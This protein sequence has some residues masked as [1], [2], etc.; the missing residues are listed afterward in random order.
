M[1]SARQTRIALLMALVMGATSAS[2]AA[3]RTKKDAAKR[4]AAT[5]KVKTK[6]APPEET[7]EPAAPMEAF[8][9]S[10]NEESAEAPAPAPAPAATA[11]Q[12]PAPAPTP[13]VAPAKP[14]LM[15]AAVPAATA[16][17]PAPEAAP[18]APVAAPAAQ[19]WVGSVAVFAV[20]REPGSAE[21]AL[22]LQEEL[23]QQ[24]GGRPDVQ[25]VNLAEAFPPPAPASLLEGDKL[26]EEGKSLYDN[27][28]PEAAMP[29]FQAAADFYIE[30]PAELQ[31]E[32]L[33]RIY[34]FMG[35]SQL[36]NG[37][38]DAANVAFLRALAAEPSV[39]PD[40]GLFG[41][42][43]QSAFAAAQEE[44]QKRGK[45]TLTIETTPAGAQVTVRGRKLGVTPVTG[46]ELPAG[47]HAVV[48]SYPGYTPYAVYQE[49]ASGR[50]TEMK[51]T[52]EPTPGLA[53]MLDAARQASTEKAFDAREMPA[54]AGAI[55]D[56]L[57][58]RY[59][60]LAAVQ[61]DRK[62]RPRAELQAWDT[63]TKSR[64]RGISII[65]GSTDKDETVAGAS[66]RVHQFVTGAN[67]PGDSSFAMPEFMKKPW[68]WAAVG[69]AALV[70]TGVVVYANSGGVPGYG[71]VSGTAGLGF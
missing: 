59:V 14:N 44:S 25:L 68:F 13:A 7:V 42:E 53:P 8:G 20:A 31:P 30:H 41:G 28:D 3:K 15:P 37:D 18:T 36:L 39:Q 45:G 24:L 34:I 60:V 27:L 47:R 35:A 17:K 52:L 70:T 4:P 57:G 58:A 51:Q 49:V 22:R 16:Q 43:V 69:G 1:N 54:E 67:L 46:V 56:R 40:N 2:A 55:A 6:K 11:Q 5:K 66:E 61:R 21:A 33:A 9:T 71:P 10:S 29:K 23:S 64:L 26:F 19:D 50:P 12:A 32:R 62:A 63:R 65:P 48:I 38:K